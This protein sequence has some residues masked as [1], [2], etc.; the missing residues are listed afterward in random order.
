MFDRYGLKSV[1]MSKT[2]QI[3]IDGPV[4]AGKGTV[5]RLVASRLGY[6]YVDT[7]AMYRTVALLALRNGVSLEDEAALVDLVQQAR[8]ELKQP[9]G[10]ERDGRLTTVL[11]NGEDVS[12]KIRTE[13]VSTGTSVVAKMAKVRQELVRKQQ[14]IAQTQN[15]VMEGRDITFRVLPE[16][17]LKIYLT[18]SAEERAA[19]R[20]KELLMRGEDVTLDTVLR[21]LEARDKQDMERAVDPLQIVEGAWVLD[22]TGMTI[23][24]VVDAI[25]RKLDEVIKG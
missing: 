14:A 5:A 3:A 21:D 1:S 13:E 9:E 16:A 2:V 18:A 6:L 8:V 7:G 15:V 11:L 4:A 19:R 17:D 23:E 25:V 22:T 12:W 10:D 24:A 20:H